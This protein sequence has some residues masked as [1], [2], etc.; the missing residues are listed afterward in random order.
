MGG[1]DHL[2]NKRNFKSLR[3]SHAGGSGDCQ[4][5]LNIAQL[6]E[7]FLKNLSHGFFGSGLMTTV[8]GKN[9]VT[10]LAAYD[11]LGSSGTNINAGQISILHFY[12]PSNN[13]SQNKRYPPCKRPTIPRNGAV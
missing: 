8:T 6:T 2:L 1:G 10:P 3:S 13:P 7:H 12:S 5:K 9:Q 4:I 11:D